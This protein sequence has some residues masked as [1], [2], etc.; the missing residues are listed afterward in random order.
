MTVYLSGVG[1][2][3]RK[4]GVRWVLRRNMRMVLWSVY[5]ECCMYHAT[6]DKTY[7]G[8]AV[9]AQSTPV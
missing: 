6:H 1:L 5:W 7:A 4:E 3:I 9:H 2:T 8:W